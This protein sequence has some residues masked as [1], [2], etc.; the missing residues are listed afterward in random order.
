MKLKFSISYSTAWGE[1]LHVKIKTIAADGFEQKADIAMN[2][3]DGQQ[4]T[5][6][7]VIMEPRGHKAVAFS[8]IY[9][10]ED[11]DGNTIRQ[12]CSRVERLFAFDP[13]REYIMPDAWRDIPLQAHFYT[14]ACRT[15]LRGCGGQA[16]AVEVPAFRQT[17]VFRVSAP[18]LKPGQAVAVCGSHPALGCWNTS[19]YMKMQRLGGA[20]WMLAVNVMGMSVPIEYKYVVVDDS[21]SAFVAWEEGDNRTSGDIGIA[22]GQVLVMDGGII[23]VR[24]EMWRVA[25]MVVPVFALRSAH[26]YGVGDFG[27]LR[28]MV[29]WAVATGM[30]VI[31]TL[32]VNDTTASRSWADS[33]PY[34]A[35]SVNALHP[36]YADL[37]AA[38]TLKSKAAMTDFNR[39]RRELNSL[40]YSDYEAVDRVKDEYLRMLFAESGKRTMATEGFKAF[41][42]AGSPWLVPYTAFSILRDKFKSADF[43]VWKGFAEYSRAKA[44]KVCAD[45]QAEAG[46]IAFVQYLLHCQLKAAA[47][48]ARANGVV[49]KGDLPIGISRNSV[50]AWTSPQYFNLD[51]QTG[52]PPDAFATNGQ[53]WSFPTYNWH[54]MMADGCSWWHGRLAVMQQYFDAFRIDHVLGF[55]RI[56]EIPATAVNA[57]MGHFSPALPF[58]PGDIEYFGM[59]FRH[60]MLTQPFIND[61]VIDKLF[62][63]HAGYVRDNFLQSKGYGMYRLLPD[64]DTQRKVEAWAEGKTDENSLWIRDSLYRLVANVL[65]LEDPRTPGMYHPRIAAFREPVF[66]ALQPDD[67]DAYMRLYNN[68]FYER[69]NAYWAAV[70]GRRLTAV[71]GKTDMLAC[72]EDLGM[73]PDCVAEVLDRLRIPTLEIQTMPKQSGGEFAH[74]GSYPYRSVAAI[75]THDMPPMRLWWQENPERAQRYFTTMMQKE[76]RAPECMAAPMAEEIVAR[77]LYCPS[78]MCILAVQDWLAMDAGLCDTNPR[79]ERINVPGDGFNRWQFRMAASIERLLDSAHFNQKIKTMIARSKR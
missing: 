72:A 73:L 7:T 38:G 68:F 53:N 40:S 77:H 75:S 3:T 30:K 46:Y 49:L 16:A 57:L 31:Q 63:V 58:T 6:D 8:Y 14:A 55:F 19:R 13:M 10:V 42:E 69:H 4:W 70:A 11:N 34:N 51:M 33:Y 29:D 71:L 54:E 12:E 50:E 1:T 15:A 37:E 74:L 5:L 61:R 79:R 67:K 32:P 26:S 60:D 41:A 43:T 45:N 22:D 65:F 24:E 76:G 35:I 39:R 18:Q 28:R 59:K 17:A 52:A 48:Y 9:C 78:M 2:T 47:D 36:H 20:E 56:W 25:G 66:E 23:R 21:T 27:D 62:G 44:E 64:F